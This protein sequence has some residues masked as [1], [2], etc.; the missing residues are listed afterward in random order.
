MYVIVKANIIIV[1]RLN[2]RFEVFTAVA[3]KNALF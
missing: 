1:N 3:V 2:V